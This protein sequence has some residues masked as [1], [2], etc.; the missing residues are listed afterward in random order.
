[1]QRPVVPTLY[2]VSRTVWY[3]A[4]KG[5]R[6]MLANIS[7]RIFNSTTCLISSIIIQRGA[8]LIFHTKTS[9]EI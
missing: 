8:S 9:T 7:M 5:V 2:Q 1:M 4:E 6:K 3:L